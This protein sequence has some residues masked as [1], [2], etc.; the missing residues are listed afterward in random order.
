VP[1][2]AFGIPVSRGWYL[3]VGC[4]RP[5]LRDEP[6]F[7]A[8]SNSGPV[9]IRRAI[10]FSTEATLISLKQNESVAGLTPVTERR[11]RKDMPVLAKLYGIVIRMIRDRTFGTRLHAFYGGHELVVALQPLR[12]LQGDVPEWV[13]NFVMDWA[14]EHYRELPITAADWPTHRYPSWANLPPRAIVC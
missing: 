10:G 5:W 13:R 1:R 14:R 9:G 12:V 11:K 8:F 3:A 4:G 7:Q 6:Y 2:P